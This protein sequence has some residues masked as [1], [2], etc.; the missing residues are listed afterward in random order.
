[1][2][3]KNGGK[4]MIRTKKGVNAIFVIAVAFIFISFWS[5]IVKAD[6]SDTSWSY[7][8]NY[9]DGYKTDF[10][11]KDNYSSSYMNCQSASGTYIGKVFGGHPESEAYDCSMNC[12]YYFEEGYKRFMYNDVKES[13]FEEAAIFGSGSGTASGL[14]SPDSVYQSGVRPAS[15][16]L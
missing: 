16:H 11:N 4:I 13:G 2:V 14:W 3:K 10:R 9:L 8:F 1:M 6:A 5:G 12:S 7:N 15:D